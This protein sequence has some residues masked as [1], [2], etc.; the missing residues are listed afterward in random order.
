MKITKI[1]FF[2][3]CLTFMPTLRVLAQDPPEPGGP[4]LPPGTPIDQ[5]LIFLFGCA[6]LF[7]IYTIWRCSIAKNE[8]EMNQFFTSFKKRTINYRYLIAKKKG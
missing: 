2:A 5:N 3:F 8:L 1:F 6:L 7:G 4:E